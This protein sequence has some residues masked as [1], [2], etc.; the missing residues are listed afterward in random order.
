MNHI[1]H[2]HLYLRT[3]WM[4]ALYPQSPKVHLHESGGHR[5]E[6]FDTTVIVNEFL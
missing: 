6:S 1:S 2:V 4:T 5:V 3:E